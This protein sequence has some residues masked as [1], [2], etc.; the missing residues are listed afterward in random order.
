M[1]T[2]VV[3]A[4]ARLEAIKIDG[5]TI[6]LDRPAG[7]PGL[8]WRQFNHYTL[9]PQGSEIEIVLGATQPMDWYVFDRSYGLPPVGQGLIAARPKDASAIQEGDMTMVS[10]KVRI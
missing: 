4:A 6:P 2:L 1:G 3:P 7:S 8:K 9:P 10:R 5:Q